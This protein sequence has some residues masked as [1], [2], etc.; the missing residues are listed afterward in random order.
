[1]APPPLDDSAVQEGVIT[2]EKKRDDT[3][4]QLNEFDY[5][6]TVSLNPVEQDIQT[7]DTWL[8]DIE[9]MFQ[10]GL[11]DVHFQPSRLEYR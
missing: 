3:V 4:Q 2:S 8:T 10:S 6:Q 9:G 5:S 11:T 7:M 1:M